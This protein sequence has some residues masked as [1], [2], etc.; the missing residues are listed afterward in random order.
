MHIVL[1]KLQI[2][3]TSQVNSWLAQ[4]PRVYLHFISTSIGWLNVVE[5]LF[6]D[7]WT[8]R[9]KRGVFK[10][11]DQLE[12]ALVGWLDARNADLKPYTWTKTVEEILRKVRK[13][14][15]IYET[16]H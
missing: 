8:Q 5:R 9:L 10:N 3:K 4:H 13:Y 2:H 12:V 7:L 16:L 6:R 14:K 15:R 11:V 1:D